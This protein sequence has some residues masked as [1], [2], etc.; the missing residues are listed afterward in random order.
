VGA[1]GQ[2]ARL[3]FGEF[4]LDLDK[5]ELRKKGRP[6]RLQPQPCKVLS[7]LASRP[8]ELVTR[9][10]LRHQIWN[11]TTFVDFEQGLNFCVRQ[12]RLALD[13]DADSPKFIETAPRRGYRFV[14]PV[15]PA[16]G[17]AANGLTEAAASLPSPRY[18][19]SPKATTSNGVSKHAHGLL[20]P[21]VSAAVLTALG[22]VAIGLWF[23]GHRPTL[24]DKDKVVLADF[25]NTT[26]D[27]VFDGALRQ[28]L[29]V[30]LEQSPFLSLVSGEQIQ[31]ALRMMKQQPHTKLTPEI[32]REICQR[33]SSAAVLNGSIIQIGIQYSLILR[34]ERCSDG[35]SIA[36]TQTLASN[37][38]H[39]LDALGKASS[40][41]R[42]KLGESLASIQ[43]FSTPLEQAT[44]PSLDALQ[45][46]DLGFKTGADRSDDIAA[47]PLFQR[48]TTLDPNFA[49]AYLLLGMMYANLGEETLSKD[50]IQKAYDLRS[51]VSQREKLFIE[52]EYF[53]NNLGDLQKAQQ[54]YTVWTQTYPRDWLP[55][56]EAML[57][58]SF[59]GQPDK[60]LDEIREA[61]TLY[62]ESGL[63]NG[64]LLSAYI[65]AGR[66]DEAHA[67]AEEVK[68]KTPDTFQVRANLY[69]L[70]F[71][72]N[73][74]A[75]MEEQIA[76]SS[77]KPGLEDQL[78]NNEA[79]T[80]AYFGKLA[81]S[82]EFSRRAVAS[83]QRAE[84][85]E[86]AAAYLADTALREALLGNNSEAQQQAATALRLSTTA[87]V[88]V[89]AAI[90]FA[91]TAR[92]ARVEELAEQLG[93]NHPDDT[94]THSVH[95]PTLTALAALNRNDAPKAIEALRAAIPYELGASLYPAYYRGLAYLAV[96]QS[97]EAATEFQKILDHRGLVWN[98]PISALAHLQLGRAFAIQGDTPKARAAYQDFL[99]LWRDADPDIPILKQGKAE[100]ARLR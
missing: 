67:V 31:Q 5:G 55:R 41:I 19:D 26:G 68:V 84:E 32:A 10:E 24:T 25:V 74:R 39:V 96:H 64:N 98:L 57:L 72:Q 30:Q 42:K 18:A 48:A 89:N 91:L 95:L 9:E 1:N 27:P 97:N 52:S 21:W 92:L 36:S 65:C 6:V 35:E 22:I 63:I 62:P 44:T 77:G 20:W 88:Q 79:D 4:E 33:T 86:T 75:G 61:H 66:I 40:D 11:G 58:Y 46:Y 3:R 34:A 76:F 29:A 45:A 28:G 59:L 73:D 82:R 90:V 38:S 15:T 17:Q 2:S 69:R 81:Q 100:Y 71:L 23:R 13:D 93:K 99:T 37:K 43:K 12:I 8:G 85:K 70:A 83:A 47:I 51:A 16:A 7:A 94:L 53:S 78:L 50:N 56:N 80:A 49:L 60:A 54:V 14:F 87:N